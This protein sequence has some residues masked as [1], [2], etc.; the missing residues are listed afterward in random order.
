[1]SHCSSTRLRRHVAARRRRSITPSRRLRDRS[2]RR[3]RLE[4]LVALLVDHLALVVGDVVVFEQ[5]LADVEVARLDL[6]LRALDRA[7][8]DAGLDRLAL[9]HLQPLHDRA[10]RARRRRCAAA[11]LRATGRSASEPGSPWRPERPRSWLSM[12]RDSWRSVPMMC[13]PPGLDHLRRAAPAIRRAASAT[14]R[15]SSPRRRASRRPRRIWIC[16]LDVAAEHDVGAAAGHVGGDGDHFGRPACATI[17]ASR[18]CC[19][20]FST[21]CG[22]FSLLQHARQQLGVLD[23]GRA[24]QHHRHQH[25]RPRHR[26][27]ARRQRREAG[28]VRRG[29]RGARRRGE[30]GAQVEK[31]RDEWQGLHDAVVK[32]GRPAHHRHRAPRVAAH[33]QPAARPLGPPGRPGLARASTCRSTIRCCASSPAT[34]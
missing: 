32:A 1:M 6:A 22:S 16:V 10:A 5:L 3:R 33:R 21:W 19:L 14:A 23:R 2:P 28:A 7:R 9:G 20:A 15:A 24:D 18:A 31:L 8:D 12:R 26:H 27:R 34:A 25:G 11:D 13:R 17:S 4:E 29:R 30:E